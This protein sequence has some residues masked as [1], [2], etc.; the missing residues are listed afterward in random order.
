MNITCGDFIPQVTYSGTY[1]NGSALK[2][3]FKIKPFEPTITLSN[4]IEKGTWEIKLIGSTSFG[5]LTSRIIK[6]KID[7]NLGPPYF[8][9]IQTVLMFT[10]ILQSGVKT[11]EVKLPNIID[12]DGDIVKTIFDF[13]TASKFATYRKSSNS[14]IL[15]PTT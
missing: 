7:G 3:Y 1:S 14:I 12:P 10:V 5:G 8:E 11:Y 15:K 13:N 9:G 2:P 6:V 4:V